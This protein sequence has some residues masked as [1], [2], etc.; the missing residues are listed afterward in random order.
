M[1]VPLQ[2]VEATHVR[3]VCDRCNGA[4]AELC[5]KRKRADDARAAAMRSFLKHGWHHDPGLRSSARAT[6]A[7]ERGGS[8]RWYCPACAKNTH[9]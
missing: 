9:F 3:V 4:S 7:G 5:G 6:E 1:V 8:G 2:L